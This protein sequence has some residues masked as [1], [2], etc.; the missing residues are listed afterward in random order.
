MRCPVI[1]VIKQVERI[2]FIAVDNSLRYGR[3][4]LVIAVYAAQTLRP[5][6]ALISN[7]L[8]FFSVFIFIPFRLLM[9]RASIFLYI[10]N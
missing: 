5:I 10:Y 4:E 2:S 6:F 9:T 7:S 8:F 1:E 3:A